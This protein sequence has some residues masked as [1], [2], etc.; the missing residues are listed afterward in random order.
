MIEYT[1]E[2]IMESQSPC[3]GAGEDVK[4]Q[5]KPCCEVAALVKQATYV[6]E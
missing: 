2:Q 6:G 3:S 4:K 1:K 5:G